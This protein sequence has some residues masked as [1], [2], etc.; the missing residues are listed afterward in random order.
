MSDFDQAAGAGVNL[1]ELFISACVEHGPLHSRSDALALAASR[2]VPIIIFDLDASDLAL[3]ADGTAFFVEKESG[4]TPWPLYDLDDD[5]MDEAKLLPTLRNAH[6]AADFEEN[7]G[8]VFDSTDFSDFPQVQAWMRNIA[9]TYP[10]PPEGLRDLI[11]E[12]EQDLYWDDAENEDRAIALIVQFVKHYAPHTE[13][14]TIRSHFDEARTPI[15]KRADANLKQF[16]SESDI[17]SIPHQNDAYYGAKAYAEAE[18]PEDIDYKDFI[19]LLNA[20]AWFSAVVLEKIGRP[21]GWTTNYNDG[22]RDRMSGY[23]ADAE[24]VDVEVNDVLS[25]HQIMN[26]QQSM[27]DFLDQ[28]GL[29]ATFDSVCDANNLPRLDGTV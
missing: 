1:A 6:I 16:M 21:F 27:K 18:C 15:Q 8:Q 12:P 2:N 9:L 24:S 25:N 22:A 7:A 11:V 13:V 29:A 4:Y 5:Q 17:L 14:L 26:A 23:N 28:H 20:M 3:F 10:D 19:P